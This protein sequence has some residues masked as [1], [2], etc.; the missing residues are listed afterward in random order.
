MLF[1]SDEE[2]FTCSIEYG[3]AANALPALTLS[4]MAAT[5]ILRVIANLDIALPQVDK[6]LGFAEIRFSNSDAI[7]HELVGI[8]VAVHLR[9]E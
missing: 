8:I 4:S 6:T 2:I 7:L 3:P 5:A 9:R 1:G